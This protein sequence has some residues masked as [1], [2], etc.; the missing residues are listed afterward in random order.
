MPRKRRDDDDDDDDEESRF[1][2]K[3]LKQR[4][5]GRSYLHDDCGGET[6]VKGN[7]FYNLSHPMVPVTKMRCHGCR[8]WVEL[9][10]IK[11]ADTGERLTDFRRRVGTY[12][13]IVY[14]LWV[15]GGGF[16][17]GA[18]LGGGIGLAIGVF[19]NLNRDGRIVVALLGAV[20]LAIAIG[21]AGRS[22]MEKIFPLEFRRYR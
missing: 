4:P 8:R 22:L 19:A 11:W 6:H 7:D 12:V 21:V 16:V 5:K 2:R 13:P 18:M 15:R 20:M 3:Y 9:D 17:P 1:P 10:E 14:V